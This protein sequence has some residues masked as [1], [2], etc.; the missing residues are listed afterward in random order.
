LGTKLILS[1][2]DP[3]FDVIRNKPVGISGG[4]YC[5]GQQLH[6]SYENLNI[7]PN[8]RISGD[9]YQILI[10]DTCEEDVL[11]LE[12]YGIDNVSY[13]V[14]FQVQERL[15]EQIE[16][17]FEYKEVTPEDRFKL[18]KDLYIDYEIRFKKLKD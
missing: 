12:E 18:L 15:Q 9:L 17:M 1:Y 14:L 10:C 2:D 11:E 5:C 8:A 6:L 7:L 3:F 16:A 13:D 4:C